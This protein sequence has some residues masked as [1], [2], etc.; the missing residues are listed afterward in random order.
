MQKKNKL[1]K[2]NLNESIFFWNSSIYFRTKCHT[3]AE[4]TFF[5]Q[6]YN[7][8]NQIMFNL[9]KVAQ[10]QIEEQLNALYG[11]EKKKS[12]AIFCL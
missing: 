3:C 5:F 10:L 1:A 11:E 2:L 6:A 7:R 12:I 8:E 4:M 9:T